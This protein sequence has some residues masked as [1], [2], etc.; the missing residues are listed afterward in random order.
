MSTDSPSSQQSDDEL[1]LKTDALSGYAGVFSKLFELYGIESGVNELREAVRQA[2]YARDVA[3]EKA[4]REHLEQADENMYKSLNDAVASIGDEMQIYAEN[5]GHANLNEHFGHYQEL[6]GLFGRIKRQF[7]KARESREQ[8]DEL[9]RYA[10]KGADFKDLLN[11]FDELGRCEIAIRAS[12][13]KNRASSRKDL[14]IAAFVA[15][16]ATA[17]ATALTQAGEAIL[18]S[19]I[20]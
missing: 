4:R 16:L 20:G 1:A 5:P 8:R 17:L 12:M 18:T 14:V 10:A 6:L 2:D 13:S 11:Y 7:A 3:D 9:Y 15:I 19:M